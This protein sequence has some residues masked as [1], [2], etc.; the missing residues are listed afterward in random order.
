MNASNQS[1]T[2]LSTGSQQ[3]LVSVILP[4]YNRP[5]YLKEAIESAVQQTY[6]NIEIIVSDDCSPEKPQAVV[7]GFQDPRIIFLRNE[8]NLGMVRNIG[9]IYKKARGKYVAHL[10]DDDMWNKDFLEKLVPP[11]EA[12]PDLALAFCDHY[13]INA[14]SEINY[15]VTEDTTRYT[16]RDRLKEGVYQPFCKLGIVDSAVATPCAAVIR[17]DAFDWDDIPP[18]IGGFWDVYTNY[19]CCRSSR[20][21]YYY[22]ERLT[23]YRHHSQGYTRYN[24]KKD[25]ETKIRR[26]KHEI[27]LNE[28]L[29][30]DERLAELKPYFQKAWAHQT[31]TLGIGLLRAKKAAEA[32]PYFLSARGQHPSLRTLVALILSFTPQSLASRF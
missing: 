3:P 12:N 4:T 20:G 31:T 8:I 30:E 25:A 22:P 18:E 24:S 27:F 21:A 32:R 29:M 7:E 9:N 19:L 6:Q 23:R 14:D 2:T 11:L 5:A 10:N 28:R 17:K 1:Q 15:P 13:I 16:H 26:A